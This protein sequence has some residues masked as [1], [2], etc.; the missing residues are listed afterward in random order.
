M[1]GDLIQADLLLGIFDKWD[2]LDKLQKTIN[3]LSSEHA[4]L[5]SGRTKIKIPDLAIKEREVLGRSQ[6]FFTTLMTGGSMKLRNYL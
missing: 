1:G 5:K 3:R 2:K 4:S 6:I